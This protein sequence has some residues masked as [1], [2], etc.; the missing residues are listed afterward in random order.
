MITAGHVGAGDVVLGG[1]TYP[2]VPGS[3]RTLTNEDGSPSDLVV[4]RLLGEPPLPSLPVRATEPSVGDA[5]V[6]VG[7][8]RQRTAPAAWRGHRGFALGTSGYMRWGTNVV[9]RTGLALTAAGTKT[10]GFSTTFSETGGTL[11][12]A[13]AA[14]G[15]S[16][17]GVFVR[18]GPR[19]EL[20][21][22]AHATR[23]YA[24]QPPDLVLFGAETLVSDLSRYK[25]QIDALTG[26]DAPPP[27][28]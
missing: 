7:H 23:D 11:H 20:A 2:W 18:N 25:G 16:G 13:Q 24:G 17:G 14:P 6:M 15:D 4:F 21:G 26:A 12:E 1:V 19:W 27:A 28:R 9:E 8:G 5:V 22:I 3:E 10:W